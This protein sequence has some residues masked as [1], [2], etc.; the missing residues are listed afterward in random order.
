MIRTII[1]SP[2]FNK[3]VNR[4]KYNLAYLDECMKDSMLNHNEAPYASHAL[5]TTFLDDN[6][7]EEREF[8]IKAGF[9]WRDAAEKSV[10]YTDLGIS[11][12]MEWGINDSVIKNK[13][14]VYRTLPINVFA[15]F[16]EKHKH[17]LK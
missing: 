17:L 3:D 8:G 6:I 15:I 2:Y 11:K 16:H 14:V 10:V 9:L 13:P 7:L 12:G 1:E 5:Y 4:I